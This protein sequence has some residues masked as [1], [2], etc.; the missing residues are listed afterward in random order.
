[1][2][3]MTLFA[4]AKE[5]T[6]FDYHSLQM[7]I[8]ESQKGLWQNEQSSFSYDA[9]MEA[10]SLNSDTFDSPKMINVAGAAL[11][12]VAT[13]VSQL[14]NPIGLKAYK[15]HHSSGED[16]LHNYL[17]M[18]GIPMDLVPE[19]PKEESLIF[20]TE[21][22]AKDENIMMLMQQHLEE[23]KN[24][25]ITSGLVKALEHRGFDDL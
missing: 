12:H 23:G 9:L 11:E 25:L 21:S 10:R 2:K 22:S 13:I 3:W 20:L 17:G 18:L 6:L 7:P 16:F 14:G 15:P 5:L 4:K 24:L 1:M 8:Q 19:F